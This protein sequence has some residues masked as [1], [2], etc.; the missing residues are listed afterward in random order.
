MPPAARR[1][2]TTSKPTPAPEPVQGM[3]LPVWP[4]RACRDSVSGEFANYSCDVVESHYG[5]HASQS[6]PQSVKL[7]QDWEQ[8][9]PDKREPSGTADP[10]IT[11]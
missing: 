9:N 8:R 4:E 11:A 7:R 5:P 2:K 6:V 3:R 1:R 10:F